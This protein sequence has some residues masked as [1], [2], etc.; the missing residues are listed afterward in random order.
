MNKGIYKIFYI[1]KTYYLYKFV[2][3]SYLHKII[4]LDCMIKEILRNG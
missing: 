4:E 1:K 3:V 2:G